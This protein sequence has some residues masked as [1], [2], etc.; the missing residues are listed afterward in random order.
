MYRSRNTKMASLL[1]ARLLT[2]ESGHLHIYAH[3]F[4]ISSARNLGILFRDVNYQEAFGFGDW[5]SSRGLHVSRFEIYH[6]LRRR[7]LQKQEFADRNRQFDSYSSCISNAGT[8][9]LELRKPTPYSRAS[10]SLFVL[11][12]FIVF[13]RDF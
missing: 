9:S 4:R 12:A 1:Q 6:L 8:V 11:L 3:S 7:F 2:A 13:W 10:L 5:A